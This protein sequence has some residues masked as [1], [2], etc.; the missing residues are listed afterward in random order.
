M[1]PAPCLSGWTRLQSCHTYLHNSDHTKSE[2]QTY[3]DVCSAADFYDAGGRVLLQDI[4]NA[5]G[6]RHGRLIAK[7]EAKPMLQAHELQALETHV[8]EVFD[9]HR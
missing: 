5:Q 4:P 9:P 7:A 2:T 6:R 8:A 3:H 1:Q